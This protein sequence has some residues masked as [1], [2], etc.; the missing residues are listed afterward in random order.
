MSQYENLSKSIIRFIKWILLH[1]LSLGVKLLPIDRKKIVLPVENYSGSNTFALYKLA[2]K[3]IRDK[4]NLV[5]QEKPIVSGCKNPI[6]RAISLL[7]FLIAAS[8][9]KI[10]ITTHGPLPLKGRGTIFVEA[11]HGFPLKA[12]GFMAKEHNMNHAKYLNFLRK[13]LDYVL[14]YSSF[15]NVLLNACLGL[16]GSNYLV[17]GMPRN[18][19]LTTSPDK[20]KLVEQIF[21]VKL[22]HKKLIFYL[23]TFRDWRYTKKETLE[24]DNILLLEGF[25]WEKFVK[26][27]RD[28]NLMFF[29]KLHPLEENLLK[30]SLSR[31]LEVQFIR[32]EVLRDLKI[33]L[34]EILGAA[35]ILITDYSSV[36]F[37]YLLLDKPII[38]INSDLALYQQRRGLLLEPYN[39][40]TPGPKITRYE[41]MEGE[42]LDFLKGQDRY[43]EERQVICNLV[44]TYKDHESSQ[45][46]WNII[47]KLMEVE[48]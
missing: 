35:D 16:E 20:R 8:R 43:R 33:D 47:S 36:F 25:S 6:K 48:R 17:T 13:R 19:L 21:N 3:E 27:L 40:W 41:D 31:F 15:F 24:A 32:D 44:H 38:F 29:I 30:T 26:F 39:L 46:V 23:P 37:D 42:I 4:Y 7:K 18:D 22:N 34:Y 28:N 5:L 10:V 12:M 1:I 2:P 45:R 11:W 9:A 14:S